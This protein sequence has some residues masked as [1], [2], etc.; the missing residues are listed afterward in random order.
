MGVNIDEADDPILQIRG[1]GKEIWADIDADEYVRTPR[2]K[3]CGNDE[4]AQEALSQR[5][6]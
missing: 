4:P 5:I 2:A 6:A 1:A 3:W